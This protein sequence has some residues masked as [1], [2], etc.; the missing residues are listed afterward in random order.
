MEKDNILLTIAARGGSKGVKNKNIRD[1]CGLPLIAHTVLQAK[2]WGRA[3]KIIC[4]TDSIQIAEIAVKYGA[5]A[6]FMRPA[7]LATDTCGKVA[8]IRHALVK[9]EEFYG[10]KFNVI[11]DLDATAPVRTPED[12]DGALKVFKE[13]KPKTVFSVTPCRKNPYFNMVELNNEGF[14]RMVKDSR[15]LLRRQDAPKV[16]D[17]NASIYVYDRDY[18]TGDKTVSALSECTAVYEM[19]EYSAFD[20]DSETDYQFIEFLVKKGLVKL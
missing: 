8:V 13:K 9:A 4:S 20:I 2:K 14:A 5:E 11:I 19:G 6:P 10:K 1:L 7:E 18:L 16:Y 15:V 3:D 17:V 12:I